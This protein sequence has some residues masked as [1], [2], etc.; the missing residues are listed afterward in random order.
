MSEDRLI[1]DLHPLGA[2]CADE[3]FCMELYRA[4]AG[5][6][7]AHRDG[8]EPVVPSWSG[9]E[10][11]VNELRDGQGLAPLALAQTGGE[12][13]VSGLVSGALD[14]LGWVAS[15]RQT[16]EHDPDHRQERASAPPGPDAGP[17][18]A[19]QAHA[20]AEAEARRTG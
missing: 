3:Q 18:W 1:G 4:L 8:G 5:A 11:I 13:E 17:E 2:R 19:E 6:R 15:P 9:A 16:D 7:L 10:R 14:A 12:G 20:E